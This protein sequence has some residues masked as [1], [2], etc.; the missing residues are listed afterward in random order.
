MVK[1][2]VL[3]T[4]CYFTGLFYSLDRKIIF[5]LFCEWTTMN[6]YHFVKKKSRK[7]KLSQSTKKVFHG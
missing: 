7:K 4:P 2:K 3:M 5:Q 1:V 6:Y